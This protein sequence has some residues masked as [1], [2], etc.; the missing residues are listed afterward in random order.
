MMQR[1]ELDLSFEAFSIPL[2]MKIGNQ[3]TIDTVGKG[4]IKLEAKI[5]G[6]WLS[7]YLENASYVPEVRRNLFSVISAFDKRL[8]YISSKTDYEFVK[9]GKVKARAENV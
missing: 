5:G 7:C 2:K 3:S 1:R 9:D 8:I 4:T 6:S